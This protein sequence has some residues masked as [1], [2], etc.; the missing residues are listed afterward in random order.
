MNGPGM[1]SQEVSLVVGAV[2]GAACRYLVN[3]GLKGVWASI[4]GAI[5]SAICVW[6]YG[7]DVAEGAH[8]TAWSY[9]VLY[10]NV[11]GLA[12]ATFHTAGQAQRKLSRNDAGRP[13]MFIV[14]A[15]GVAL[16]SSSCALTSSNPTQPQQASVHAKVIAFV[17]DFTI[18]VGIVDEAG[19]IV[20]DTSLSTADKDDIDC[21]IKKAS[22]DDAPSAI[23][24]RVCG[25]IPTRDESKVRKALRDLKEVTTEA[26]LQKTIRVALEV[27]E[28][29]WQKL[30]TSSNARLATLGVILELTL[31]P[32]V[33][34]TVS[35]GTR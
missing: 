19:Y 3:A 6:A 12:S 2:V 14:V 25:S 18:A 27:L 11:L 28:P 7:R 9:L 8:V 35:G 26:S 20:N 22:G 32:A 21:L 16:A 13:P 5:I 17:D 10:A 34:A 24:L 15:L 30:K 1:E 23:Q 29:L 4:A 33:Q 31:R